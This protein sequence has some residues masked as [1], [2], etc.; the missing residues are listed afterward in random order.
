MTIA[1]NKVDKKLFDI[2][3]QTGKREHKTDNTDD[4]SAKHI[5]AYLSKLTEE[6]CFTDNIK[7]T[8]H[9]IR[10]SQTYDEAVNNPTFGQE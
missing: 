10:I 5:R 7:S 4:H 6:E 8:P 3:P 1:T 9:R 2:Q